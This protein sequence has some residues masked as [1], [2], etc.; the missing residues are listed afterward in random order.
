ML[1][2]TKG[3]KMKKPL[4]FIAIDV[5]SNGSKSIAPL[6]NPDGELM[7]SESLNT[8]GL[9]YSTAL[10]HFIPNLAIHTIHDSGCT[11]LP[12]IA[13]YY[14]KDGQVIEASMRFTELN[15]NFRILKEYQEIIYGELFK[16]HREMYEAMSPE[17]KINYTWVNVDN[18]LK[19]RLSEIDKDFAQFLNGLLSEPAIKGFSPPIDDWTS[20]STYTVTP[21]KLIKDPGMTDNQ[22]IEN[23]VI[24]PTSPLEGYELVTEDDVIKRIKEIRK[25]IKKTDEEN[26]IVLTF[27][28]SM[29][30]TATHIFHITK[31]NDLDKIVSQIHVLRMRKSFTVD[32]EITGKYKDEVTAKLVE[33]ETIARE[34]FSNACKAILNDGAS[35]R[36]EGLKAVKSD[37]KS[38]FTWL[39]GMF[40]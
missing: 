23:E 1:I 34:A 29:G 7:V 35:L 16:L 36:E 8:A 3:V 27:G 38:F 31:E 11:F 18:L 2:K 24:K 9:M 26:Q 39:K 28:D 6:L 4:Y 13:E 14:P 21:F 22:S 37:R 17:E 30:S 32:Y 40:K 10:T 33:L 20:P 12:K 15:D 19:S 5:V 25:Q